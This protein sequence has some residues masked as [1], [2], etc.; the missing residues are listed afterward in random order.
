MNSYGSASNFDADSQVLICRKTGKVPCA[1][2]YFGGYRV[3]RELVVFDLSNFIFD[4]F[5]S[6]ESAR[7]VSLHNRLWS[8]GILSACR[9][10][11]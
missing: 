2:I 10:V 7:L 8:R 3:Y 1:Q 9:K 11:I 4:I 5:Y 6:V